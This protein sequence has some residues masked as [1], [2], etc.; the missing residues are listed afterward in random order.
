MLYIYIYIG[1]RSDFQIFS[2]LITR[3][4][5]NSLVLTKKKFYF[6]RP[7]PARVHLK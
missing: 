2:I 6:G 4:D 3:L 1:V 5:Q 7:F